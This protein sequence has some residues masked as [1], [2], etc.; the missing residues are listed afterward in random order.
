[1][2]PWKWCPDEKCWIRESANHVPVAR[3]RP[4]QAGR[5]TV[6]CTVYGSTGNLG[7]NCDDLQDAARWCDRQLVSMAYRLRLEDEP[8]SKVEAHKGFAWVWLHA[9]AKRD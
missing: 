7:R 2:K 9:R 5:S 1:M 8:V 3:I 4:P 6:N